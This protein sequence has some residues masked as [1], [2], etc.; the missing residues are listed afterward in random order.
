MP[1]KTPQ[2]IK[3]RHQF[4]ER[5]GDPLFHQRCRHCGIKRQAYVTNRDNRLHAIQY[6]YTPPGGKS[7]EIFTWD[8]DCGY[9]RRGAYGNISLPADAHLRP[10]EGRG[11]AA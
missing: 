2:C 3:P 11:C 6:Y 1:T 5:K 10:H 4:G 8:G 7:H 9:W